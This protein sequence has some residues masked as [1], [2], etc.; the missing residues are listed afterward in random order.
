MNG[1]IS[2]VCRRCLARRHALSVRLESSADSSAITVAL[3]GNPNTGKTTVFNAL[4]GL[5]YHT[6]NWTGK[7]VELA[8][9]RMEVE[10][11]V[12]RLVDLPG[13]YSLTSASPDETVAREFLLFGGSRVT[14][15]VVDASRLE[16]GLSFLLQVLRLTP[17]VVLCVNLVDEAA[18][19]GLEINAHG[20]AQDLGIPVVLTAARRGRGLD[21]LRRVIHE[22]AQGT[23]TLRPRQLLPEDPDLR[24][25]VHEIARELAVLYPRLPERTGVAL[26]LLSGDADVAAAVREGRLGPTRTGS[27]D[28]AA[29]RA[30]LE[31]VTRWRFA[32]PRDAIERWIE[33]V[34]AEAA[35]LAARHVRQTRPSR[36]AQ[37]ERA[38]DRWLTNPWTG[39]PTMLA[40][41]AVVLWITIE[42]AN[43]PS[44]W[45]FRVLVQRGHGWV[46]SGL[47]ALGLSEAWVSLL[48]D[49]AYRTTAWVVSVMLPPMAIFFPLFTLLE[50]FGYLPR[51]AFNLDPLFRR[52]GAH[53][54]QALTMTMGWGCNA[55]GVVAT[56][57]I[58][59]PRER[60][61]AILTNNFSL[62]NGR[63]P[64][65]FM[66]AA[67]FL[68]PLA[69]PGWEGVVAAGA[70]FGIALLGVALMFATSWLLSRTVLRGEPS[71][72]SLELPPYRPPNIWA[73]LYTSLIDRTIIVL[74]RAVVFACPAGVVLWLLG[75]VD[76]GGET[77]ARL[78]VRAL[79]PFGRALGLDGVIL[80]AYI[81]A[82]PANEIVL[83]TVLVLLSLLGASVPGDGAASGLVEIGDPSSLGVLLRSHGW[84]TLT[85][86]CLM[87]FSLC[88][89]P[90]STTIF[91][92]YRET[93]SAK[94]AAVATLLPLAIGVLLCGLV[95]WGARRLG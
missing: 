22:V 7:T 36:R 43:V 39:Y 71:R 29:A 80:T 79:D 72:F 24:A 73:T 11:Q 69:P 32:L 83:P 33:Q 56:R 74:W 90:C 37:W 21:E 20:L 62:C 9:G 46:V 93:K 41:L 76:L 68:G 19:H 89:N 52:V 49:G 67:I 26:R 15:V 65:Q 45:L 86:V 53:G 10:G 51:V 27:L 85:G 48:A 47:S 50:D 23:R 31:R 66:M 91:T 14:V 60:L 57:I 18:A 92:I 54:R 30:L 63:W 2:E 42:G 38:L 1:A 3:A 87:L 4:T 64:T 12:Y 70:V 28:P 61:I 25:A 16:R 75:R 35:E 82:I 58:D 95:A 78:M 40:L 8:E 94:W 59:S 5:R 13:T 34:F 81:V 17:H 84:T 88:H 6:G 55:A 44:Q 77:L